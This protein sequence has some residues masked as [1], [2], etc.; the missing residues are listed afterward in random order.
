MRQ[1]HHGNVPLPGGARIKLMPQL[2]GGHFNREFGCF[3]KL[4]DISPRNHEWQFQCSRGSADELF[5]GVTAPATQLMIEVP[6]RQLPAMPHRKR[7]K[8]MQ[9][10]HRIQPA[11]HCH[12]DRLAAFQQAP[13]EDILF[14]ALEQIGHAPMLLHGGIEARLRESGWCLNLRVVSVGA[15]RRCLS[16]HTARALQQIRIPPKF[17]HSSESLLA[18]PVKKFATPLPGD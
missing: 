16:S 18:T 6:D 5:I 2:S 10:R 7:A 1:R 13:V 14:D 4:P 8:D 3:G 17:D 15:M 11:G 12:Q 9:K